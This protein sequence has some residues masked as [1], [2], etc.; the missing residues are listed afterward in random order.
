SKALARPTQRPASPAEQIAWQEANREWWSGHPMRYDWKKGIAAPEASVEFYGEIDRRFFDSAAAFLPTHG[1]PFDALIDF[2]ALRE[3]H[4]VLKPGGQAT[5]MVYHRSPWTYYVLNG[6]LGGLLRGHL[7]RTRSLHRAV[8][9]QTDGALARYYSMREW[10]A[11][12][13]PY[14]ITKTL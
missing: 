8:Q 7:L 13:A 1:T 3:M 6:L 12:A 4:G 10:R 9:L 11:L 14:F 2:E 5:V